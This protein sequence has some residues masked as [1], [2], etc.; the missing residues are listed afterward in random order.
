MSIETKQCTKCGIE[1]PLNAFHNSKGTRDG[2]T[3]Q[4]KQCRKE[5][6]RW[7]RGTLKGIYTLSKGMAKFRGKP[8]EITFDYFKKW[9]NAQKQNCVYCGVQQSDLKYIDDV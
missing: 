6:G 9:W 1:K 8:F 5:Y 4:C 3:Y 7:F 2:K